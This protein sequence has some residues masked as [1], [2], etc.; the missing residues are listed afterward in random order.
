MSNHIDRAIDS[1]LGAGKPVKKW[2][3]ISYNP[4]NTGYFIHR[5]IVECDSAEDAYHQSGVVQKGAV[6]VR[7]GNSIGIQLPGEAVAGVGPSIEEAVES[8]RQVWIGQLGDLEDRDFWD[9]AE[10]EFQASLYP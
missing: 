7:N 3:V 4:D 10:R 9:D 1:L 2:Y 6:A 5:E 8:L